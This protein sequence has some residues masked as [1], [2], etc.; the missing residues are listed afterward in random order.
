MVCQEV[1]AKLSIGQNKCL[2]CPLKTYR[3]SQENPKFEGQRMD[4][5]ITFL[6]SL[7]TIPANHVARD[8]DV[9]LAN[10]AL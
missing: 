2:L 4:R 10:M 3:H 6:E 5:Q 7:H 8:Q 1:L 9:C